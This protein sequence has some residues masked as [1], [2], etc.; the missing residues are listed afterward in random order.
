MHELFWKTL[1][2]KGAFWVK[3]LFFLGKKCNLQKRRICPENSK[4]APDEN[5]YA[6]FCPRRKAANFCQPWGGGGV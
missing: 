5:V 2:K 3:N 6:H 1:A 4:Y